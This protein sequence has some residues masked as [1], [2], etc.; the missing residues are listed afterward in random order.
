MKRRERALVCPGDEPGNNEVIFQVKMAREMSGRDEKKGEKHRRK[1]T[2]KFIWRDAGPSL[3]EGA[4][5]GLCA[6]FFRAFPCPCF[7]SLGRPPLPHSSP[8][9][10]L[11]LLHLRLI[12]ASILKF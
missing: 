3:R 4:I 2:V 9:V 10:L 12:A 8:L 5:G 11:L 6:R 1:G 7:F